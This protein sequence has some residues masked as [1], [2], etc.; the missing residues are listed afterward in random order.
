MMWE[1]WSICKI[2]GIIISVFSFENILTLKRRS[3][4]NECSEAKENRFE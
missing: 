2:T 3:Y 4:G 1:E